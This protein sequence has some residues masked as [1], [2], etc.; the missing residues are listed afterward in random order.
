MIFISLDIRYPYEQGEKVR[1]ISESEFIGFLTECWEKKIVCKSITKEKNFIRVNGALKFIDYEILPYSDNLFLNSAARAFMYLRYKNLSEE[2]YNR[3]KRSIIN[4]FHI[5]EME[6]FNEFLNKLFFNISFHRNRTFLENRKLENLEKLKNLDES[7]F[8]KKLEKGEYIT[9][10]IPVFQIDNYHFKTE[11]FIKT[12]KLNNLNKRVSLLI[13]TCP[14]ESKTIY[15]QVKH[16][17]KQLSCPDLFL[18][19]VIAI[20]KK[21]KDFLREYTKDGSLEELYK[22]IQKLIDEGIIDYYIELPEEEIE[23]VNY[24]W[25]GLK[26]KETH[27][28]NNIP[29][30]PQVYAFEKVKGDYILQMDSD[31]LIGREDYNHSFLDD[32]IR[33]LEENENAVSVGF[34]IPK[35]KDIVFTEYH[36][37]EGGYKPGVRFALI[38]KKRL[39]NARPLPN[40]L[41]KGRLKWGWY[42]SL[43]EYQ[44][45]NGLVSLRGGSS[46]SYYIHPQ[47]FRKQCKDVWFTILDRVEKNIIPDIQREHF[48]LE[49]SFY[50]WTIHKRNEELIIFTILEDGKKLSNFFRFFYSILN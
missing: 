31:V 18:E 50:D 32:M 19:K 38:H 5:E 11:F 20:D 6:G 41:V 36:A 12:K 16:I 10:V 40:K 22:E 43:H 3:I 29:V 49:G 1:E 26:T 28:I 39:L 48:D 37:P 46:K 13:K 17:V 44:K 14:Q 8:W 21:E 24:R 25:F 45:K 15:Q 7:I 23:E 47:N 33:A 9:E 27:T 4:N 2:K 42:H 34:N 35:S 30:T